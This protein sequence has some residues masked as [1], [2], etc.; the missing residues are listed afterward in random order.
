MNQYMTQK[1]VLKNVALGKKFCLEDLHSRDYDIALSQF[2]P[3]D[4]IAIYIEKYYKFLRPAFE[5][6]QAQRYPAKVQHA[7]VKYTGLLYDFKKRYEDNNVLGEDY[8]LENRKDLEI[9]LYRFLQA[10]EVLQVIDWQPI[11]DVDYSELFL[12]YWVKLLEKEQ[13]NVLENWLVAAWRTYDWYTRLLQQESPV[14][15]TVYQLSQ[16]MALSSYNVRDVIFED[17][18]YKSTLFSKNSLNELK[19]DLK[20]I[21]D[22]DAEI[23]A[24]FE[25][26]N[27]TRYPDDEG[28]RKI[29]YAVG[30]MGSDFLYL[31]L[32]LIDGLLESQVSLFDK[33]YRSSVTA[34]LKNQVENVRS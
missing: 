27:T 5:Y 31:I 26:L 17:N 28:F 32:D 4:K 12:G 33:K 19:M 30:E 14:F 34:Y 22:K 10:L 24:M 8:Y 1:E 6:Y 16:D 15:M 13:L 20:E 25:N 11:T 9:S 2:E 18:M 3:S 29:T 23:E 21:A 7:L